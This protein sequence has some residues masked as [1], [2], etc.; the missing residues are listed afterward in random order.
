MVDGEAGSSIP[1]G[2]KGKGTTF[3][4]GMYLLATQAL[5]ISSVLPAR[6][7]TLKSPLNMVVRQ[8]QAGHW[9]P[10]E[11]GAGGMLR[12]ACVHRPEGGLGKVESVHPKDRTANG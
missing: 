5:I 12:T 2:I 10:R 3:Q 1:L 8:E 6:Q 4:N 11:W 9:S 7:P